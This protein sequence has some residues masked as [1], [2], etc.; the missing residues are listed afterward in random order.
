MQNNPKADALPR[1]I[2]A[3]NTTDSVSNSTIVS[4]ATNNNNNGND[5]NSASNQFGR[6]NLGNNSNNNNRTQGSFSSANRRIVSKTASTHRNV[7]DFRGRCR[8]EIDSRADTVCCGKGFVPI[9]D[10]D[11]ECDVYGFHPGMEA[12]KN[13]PVRTCATAY[14]HANGETIILEFGQALWFGDDLEHSLLSL[15][16]VRFFQHTVCLNPKQFSNGQS[17]HGIECINDEITFPFQ[18]HGCI[19]YMPI[20]AP[21]QDKMDNCRHILMTSEE[22]WD[23]Y[24]DNFSIAEKV[25]T[26]SEKR[27][28]YATSSKDHRSNVTPETLAQRWGTSIDIASKTLKVTTQ[29]GIRNILS[30]L[31]R[32]F[33]TRQTHL[34]YKYLNTDVYSDT[35]FSQTKSAR[36]F[37]C[38]QLFV[39]NQDFAEVYPMRSKSEAPYK[40]DEFCKSYGLPKVLV[41]DNAPEETAGK[42]E[43]VAKQYLLSQQTTEPH[44]GWQNRAELEIRELKKHFRRIMH[45]SRCPEA[46]WCYGLDYTKDIRKLTARPSLDWRTPMETISGE[47]PDCTEYLEF[48]FFGWVK[49]KDPTQG[50][51]DDI[52]L[53]RWLGVAHSVGQAM[54]Y[55]ILKSNGYVV[56]RS[57]VR[58]IT[59]EE[60][61]SPEEQLA[62]SEFMKELIEH[63]RDFDPELINTD[64]S[65]INDEMVKPFY[66]ENSSV[67][68]IEIEDNANDITSGPEPL[69]NAEVFLPHGDRNEI[70]KVIGRKRSSDGLY[71]GRKHQN[72]LLDSRIFVVEFP[73]GDHKD[74]AYNILAEHLYSQIDSEGNQY[75]LFKEIINHRKKKSAVEKSDQFRI[76]HRN[77]K[78]EKKKTTA[79]WDLEIE[80]KDGSTSW[81]PLKELKETNGIIVA[82]YA[83][84]NLIDS[85]PAFDWW[86]RG[87]LK[88]EKRLIKKTQRHFVKQGYKFGIRIPKTVAE[89]IALDQENGNTFW[90]DAI[91]KELANVRVAFDVLEQGAKAPVGY[92]C[93]P[94]RLIFDV[95]MDF[96]RK[97]RFVAGGHVTDPPSSITYSSVV[98]RESVCIA[99]LVAALNDLKILTSDIGNAY[100]N[101]RTSEK[102]YTITGTEFGEEC[103]RVAIIVRALYGLKSSGAAWHAMFAQSIMDLGFVSCKSD[104]DVW[105]RAA[106]KSTGFKYYEYILVYVDDCIIVSEFPQNIL[107]KFKSNY[108]YRLKDVGE[109][110]RFLGAKIGR[111]VVEGK[112]SWF[113]SAQDYLEKALAT[114]EETYGKLEQLFKTRMDTPAPTDFHPEIDSTEFLDD[115]T[116]TL[117]QSYIGILRWAVELGRIDLNHFAST[118]AKFSA[119]PREGH[120]FALIRFFAYVK[121]HLQSG[122]IINSDEIYWTSTEWVSKDWDRFYPDINGELLPPDMPEARGHPVQINL[123]CDASHANDLMTRRSTTGFVF[124]LNGTPVQWYSKRQNT[125][126]GSTFGSEFVAL[127]IAADANEALRYKLRMF[128]IAIDGPTNTFCDNNSVAVNVVNPESTLHKKH[129]AIAYHCV[130]ECV[131]MGSMRVCHEA[132]K[133]NCSDV[134]TK[135]LP[136]DAH[137]RCCA[138]LLYR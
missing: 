117:Y 86:V 7:A 89:A 58:P 56:A 108:N 2:G 77:G 75:R 14:D 29:R 73:D 106:T 113:I 138:C 125:I 41:T 24:S 38:A 39:T 130:R 32:R 105:R 46:F 25:F 128:G 97:A 99:F 8:L 22:V 87:L 134:L 6:R 20:R 100:L 4:R 68:D 110:S 18:M 37:E 119:S 131:A 79:G 17:L 12:V 137:F 66:D 126:E 35:L 40:L 85:E 33:R 70:A 72:P 13:V 107:D 3:T 121:K 54:T 62:Q 67:I 47:T 65:A 132:G 26:A 42:W 43:K 76:D 31:S 112:D 91:Q 80:W 60:R 74:V 109:P 78:Q 55:W 53:G 111:V 69:Q 48:D 135:F 96:T 27:G 133:Y 93:I 36:S 51:A 92:K 45:R 63:V 57:T 95:K 136:K 71:I 82:K 115:D 28:V 49:F 64:E 21:T 114:I 9:G 34:R 88:K 90:F 116:T 30:P 5:N 52:T 94:C 102:V 124:I 16:Q 83:V 10:T 11:I 61:R 59:D 104:P 84:D 123:F 23:P 44:S 81:L 122:I 15:D 50:L 19:S 127:K 129:N 118:M 98:S 101:A 1:N 103:G 120:L